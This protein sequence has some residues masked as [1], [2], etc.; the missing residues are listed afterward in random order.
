MIPKDLDLKQTYSYVDKMFNNWFSSHYITFKPLTTLTFNIALTEYFPNLSEF[1]SDQVLLGMLWMYYNYPIDWLHFHDS[2]IDRLPVYEIN[3]QK[4][5]CFLEE[6][7]VS[8][9]EKN[10]YKISKLFFDSPEYLTRLPL[11]NRKINY[12]DEK[13]TSYVDRRESDKL[14]RDDKKL[15]SSLNKKLVV[16]MQDN[17][18]KF[19]IVQQKLA[20]EKERNRVILEKMQTPFEKVMDS[21]YVNLPIF[22]EQL[23]E[24]DFLSYTPLW[25]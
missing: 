5:I 10:I 8:N 9:I 22:Q 15:I 23:R 1:N 19:Q 17:M 6:S 25:F 2:T 12:F 11:M 13:I 14:F 7:G 4:L 18:K 16:K 21:G 3:L 20:D 24:N